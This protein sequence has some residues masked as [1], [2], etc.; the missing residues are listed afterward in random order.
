MAGF[1]VM[2]DGVRNLALCSAEAARNTSELIEK[3]RS[4]P[5]TRMKRPASGISER[6]EPWAGQGCEASA[7]SRGETIR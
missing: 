5:S 3:R 6:S 7:R 1:A 4:F 2:A